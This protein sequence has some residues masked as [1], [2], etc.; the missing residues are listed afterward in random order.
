M[1][2]HPFT[3][4][5]SSNIGACCLESRAAAVGAVGVVCNSDAG[6]TIS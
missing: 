4:L 6:S 2:W 3:H 5:V 1:N